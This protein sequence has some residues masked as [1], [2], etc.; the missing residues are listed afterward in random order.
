MTQRVEIRMVSDNKQ[1]IKDQEALIRKVDELSKS[2]DKAGKM[3]VKAAQGATGSFSRLEKE[4]KDNIA[5]LKRMEVGTRQFEDQ[6]QKVAGLARELGRAKSEMGDLSSRGGRLQMAAAGT[7]RQVSGVAAGF[8]SI[9]TAISAITS[10]FDKVKRIQLESAAKTRT[11]EE[12]LADIAFNV[13]GSDLDATRKL[14][15]DNAADLGTSQKGLANLIGLAISAGAKD[16]DEAL[17]VSTASLKATA[18]DATKASELVQSALDIASLSGSKNFSGALGQVSQTQSQVRATNASEF[19]SNLGPALAA[20]TAKG[21]NIDG[22]STE[23]TLELSSVVSQIIKDRTGAN[24]A[25]AVRQFVTRLDSFTPALARTLKDGSKGEVSADVIEQF[26][27][28]RNV[29]ERID[30]F[31]E[32]EGLRRQF[33]DQQKEGIGKSAIREI[34][35]GTERA[36]GIEDKASQNITS[37][38]DA[39]ASFKALTD[40]VNRNTINLRADRKFQA[41]IESAQTGGEAGLQGQATK[42]INDTIAQLDLPG[43]DALQEA[44]LAGDFKVARADKR[45]LGDF[46]QEVLDAV[47][48]NDPGFLKRRLD[49]TELEIVAAARLQLQ[50]LEQQIEEVRQ[51]KAQQEKANALLQKIA[52]NG[53]PA[54]A[55]PVDP[56]EAPP[57]AALVP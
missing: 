54:N 50:V 8:L 3:S 26:R 15:E 36:V 4:L 45:N 5:A 53:D 1:A 21:Q 28:T 10:E 56:V 14:V 46:G 17:K 16:I 6:K 30:L 51:Q 27:Q 2:H 34:I 41:A 29:D 25:T 32:N 57:P 7:A 38:D 44:A 12:A 35:S 31:R 11:F 23:R 9:N 47:S 18:G 43:L 42:I 20:A 49:E 24:T 33:L 55:R 52:D 22:L 37:I 13:G 40:A 39:Q 48:T 19:F